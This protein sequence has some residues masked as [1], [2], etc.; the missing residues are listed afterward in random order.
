MQH[1]MANGSYKRPLAMAII[2]HELSAISFS[3]NLGSLIIPTAIVG[4]FV[5]C[6]TAFARWVITWPTFGLAILFPLG[7]I[8]NRNLH[9]LGFPKCYGVFG[10]K[11]LIVPI[12]S[13]EPYA[14]LV[15][16]Q[17]RHRAFGE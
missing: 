8:K 3:A 11:T 7:D 14:V 1:A 5:A 16:C 2:S 13:I 15:S 17:A 12:C 6:F 10:G 4:I 9:P